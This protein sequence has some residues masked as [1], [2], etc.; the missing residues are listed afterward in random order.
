MPKEWDMREY[1]SGDEVHILE[2]QNS[3]MALEDRRSLEYWRWEYES[4][5]TG[6]RTIC[7]AEGKDGT[8]AGHYALMPLRMKVGTREFSGA[9]S[10][11]TFTHHEYRR[12]GIFV[13]LANAVYEMAA[14]KGVS[15]FYGFPSDSSYPGFVEKLDWIRVT[16]IDKMNKALTL[17]SIAMSAFGTIRK[18]GPRPFASLLY[19]LVLGWKKRRK[20]RSDKPGLVVKRIKR[21]DKDV[22]KLWENIATQD[23]IRVVKDST[24]LNWRYVKKPENTYMIFRV[25]VNQSILGY[26][27]FEKKIAIGR[28]L[29]RCLLLDFVTETN[30]DNI[31]LLLM[32]A[33]RIARKLGGDSLTVWSSYGSIPHSILLKEGYSSI[34]ELILISRQ[35][36]KDFDSRILHDVKRWFIMAGDA[37]TV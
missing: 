32:I 18:H 17:P 20:L 6:L 2:Y 22:D 24:Y 13:T 23:E 7:I 26:L 5:P 34:G 29:R 10:V 14:Q 16:T 25:H 33:S 9:Q 35:N 19:K 30:S 1:Q 21:F 28:L 31:R 37:D 4:N 12:L 15:V 27:V 36:R 3:T 8:L 11:D